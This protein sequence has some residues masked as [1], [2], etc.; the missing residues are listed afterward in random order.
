M[1]AVPSDAAVNF[2]LAESVRQELGGKLTIIGL[3]PGNQITIPKGTK[4]LVTSIAFAFIVLDGDGTFSTT[5]SLRAPSGKVIFKDDF[6]QRSVKNPGEPL[7]V[8]IAVQPFVTD[9][10][11]KFDISLHLDS[12]TY[13]RSFTVDFA[14]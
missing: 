5:F 9:E 1:T 7:I 2:L 11:G 12:A 13:P 8:L 3:Y 6:L 14:P 10:T 4:Q